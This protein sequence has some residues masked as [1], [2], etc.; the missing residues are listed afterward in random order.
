MRS[1]GIINVRTNPTDANIMLGSG[2]YGN[3]EKRMSDYGNYTMYIEKPEYLTNSLKFSIDSEKPFFIE[4]ISL[5]PLPLYKQIPG[6]ID[7]Y[8]VSNEESLQ[9][10]ASGRIKLESTGQYINYS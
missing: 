8:H 9:K 4:K 10:T 7:I 2:S 1:F 5:L 3:N 6:I